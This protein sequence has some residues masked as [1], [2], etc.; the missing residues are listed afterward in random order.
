MGVAAQRLVDA[1]DGRF[2][3]I[4]GQACGADELLNAF[5]ERD[6]FRELRFG[7]VE[8][9]RSL[10]TITSREVAERIRDGGEEPQEWTS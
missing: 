7:L 6:A 2:L 8:Q 9:L 5:P 4:S 1:L 3:V 10:P